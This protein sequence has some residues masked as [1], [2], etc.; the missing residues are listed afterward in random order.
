MRPPYIWNFFEDE[1]PTPHVLRPS[2]EPDKCYIDGRFESLWDDI[3]VLGTHLRNNES[4][5]WKL[6]ISR[7]V[8]IFK[9]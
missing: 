4:D 8:E 9:D 1:D 5:T 3:L 7:T 6:L 2:A